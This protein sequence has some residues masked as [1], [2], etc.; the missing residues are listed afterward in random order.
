MQTPDDSID[1]T[2]IMDEQRSEG[3]AARP[4]TPPRKRVARAMTAPGSVRAGGVRRKQAVARRPGSSSR[5]RGVTHHC[6][7]GRWEAHIWEDGKQVYLGGFDNEEQAALAYDIA[8]IKFRAQDA[9]TN[10]NISNYEQE[11]LHFDEVSKEEV[12]QSLRKQSRGAQKTSSQYRGVTKHQ[13]GK[14][15]ARIGQMVG[16]KYKYLGLY[17][18]EIEAATAYDRE[19]VKRRGIHAVTNFDLA[20][21]MD[22]LDEASIAEAESRHLFKP[23]P[24]ATHAVTTDTHQGV[25]YTQACLL[26]VPTH[27]NITLAAQP[28]QHEGQQGFSDVQLVQTDLYHTSEDSA[29]QNLQQYGSYTLVSSADSPAMHEQF[30]TMDNAHSAYDTNRSDG[31]YDNSNT[32]GNYDN[33]STGAAVTWYGSLDEHAALGPSGI[34]HEDQM[35]HAAWNNHQGLHY[36]TVA[37]KNVP[38]DVSRQDTPTSVFDIFN[39]LYI[40][41]PQ[42]PRPRAN[43][44]TT[45]HHEPGLGQEPA[46]TDIPHM[47]NSSTPG[48]YQAMIV[49]DDDW[50]QDFALSQ[51]QPSTLP[52]AHAVNSLAP[53]ESAEPPRPLVPSV[54]VPDAAAAVDG[55][56]KAAEQESTG[57]ASAMQGSAEE[58]AHTDGHQME[59]L[60]E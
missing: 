15:E 32:G 19:A 45:N 5:F 33:S 11:L 48:N 16:R 25:Y 8:A 13:K 56:E 12:V 22:L 36:T 31:N 40:V 30:I 17:K 9:N 27:R 2:P 1:W 54:S 21:Y 57:N 53:E 50:L 60:E 59:L 47:G 43:Q 26:T 4:L 38:G 23:K 34:S 14:W 7:T 46:L 28:M 55:S 35:D 3:C 42:S 20:E 18:E 52:A 37:N 44:P 29:V 10:Y 24:T 6:R 58:S 41:H 51:L 39:A 49:E